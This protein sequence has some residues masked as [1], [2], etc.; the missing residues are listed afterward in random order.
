MSGT[1]SRPTETSSISSLLDST[2]TRDLLGLT[3]IEQKGDSS[4]SNKPRRKTVWESLDA[5]QTVC[6]RKQTAVA[7]EAHRQMMDR[8]PRS[9]MHVVDV[10]DVFDQAAA[11]RVYTDADGADKIF[12]LE[13]AGATKPS[14]LFP[15]AIRPRFHSPAYA[16][17]G[18]VAPPLPKV[19][20]S[21]ALPAW[22]P[23]AYIRDPP[24]SFSDNYRPKTQ[25]MASFASEPALLPQTSV[26]SQSIVD[27]SE[28]PTATAF[29]G[30]LGW[31]CMEV[32]CG[33]L[34]LLFLGVLRVGGLQT[35]ISQALGMEIGV[36]IA[37]FVGIGS[38]VGFLMG[39][40]T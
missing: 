4:K 5:D 10:M 9:T 39:R 16:S 31:F 37:A 29:V 40:R 20:T 32:G 35:Y 7:M 28:S 19:S 27:G 11:G 26:A 1:A 21:S 23:V 24:S 30:Y 25:A 13:F 18:A 17:G 8:F 3:P 36:V 12:L 15:G 38:A 6:D 2:A 34:V 33:S 14:P 22:P